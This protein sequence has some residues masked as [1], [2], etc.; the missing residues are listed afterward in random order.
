MGQL[1]GNQDDIRAETPMP[2][3]NMD[4]TS[5]VYTVPTETVTFYYNLAGVKT[6]ATGQ[7]AGTLIYA[8]LGYDGILNSLGTAVANAND[9]SFAFV[10]GTVLTTQVKNPGQHFVNSLYKKTLAQK[11]EA[12][13]LHLTTNGEFFID[14]ENG[15]IWGLAADT[16]AD[17]TA[18]YDVKTTLTGGGAGDK[19]DVTKVGGTSVPIMNEAFGTA[20]GLLPIGGKY[21]ATPT[22]YDDGDAAP[23]LLDA[24]GR[25]VLNS[26]IQIGAVEIK[27]GVTDN[28][29]QVLAPNTANY[30]YGMTTMPARYMASP[31]NLI[32]S[33]GSPL[34]L[35]KTGNLKVIATGTGS[36]QYAEDSAHVSGDIGNQVL[37]VR[38]DSLAALAGTDGDYAPFQ[39]SAAGAL[40]TGVSEVLGAT[41]SAT[42][43]VFAELTDGTAV[44][45]TGN[46][47]T[48]SL[49]DATSIVDIGIDE[50]AMAATPNFVPVGGEYRA[51]GTTYTDGDATVLQSTVDGHVKV[52]A[53]GYDSGTDSQ[54]V[55]EVAPLNQQYLPSSNALTTVLNATPQYIYYDMSGYKF[56]TIE[57]AAVDAGGGDTH[58]ITLEGTCQDDGTAAASC[59]YQDV[60]AALTGVASVA[61]TSTWIIDTPV[62]FKY[63]RVKDTTAGGNNDGGMTAYA[64]Q[65]Y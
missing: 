6:S 45:G 64:K 51:A 34:L 60:T 19:V 1:V 58:I 53:D 22:T 47:L 21:M 35:D 10:T 12:M 65:M 59:T 52:Q 23:I 14:H 3:D 31:P 55:Y 36:G 56:I 9:T 42:N 37:S 11:F 44:I 28:R 17:D 20:T 62:A 39:V 4:N 30:E 43:P 48:V 16:V 38:N 49:S 2:V 61:A 24:Q 41:M 27:D 57:I 32:N 50:S 18:G 8:K 25:I 7:A 54:K 46:P 15:A 5:V 13:A 40:Y 29:T 26:D 33:S 63:L